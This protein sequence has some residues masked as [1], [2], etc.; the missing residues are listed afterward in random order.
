MWERLEWIV[1]VDRLIRAEESSLNWD[2]ILKLASAQQSKTS[3]LL[4][5]GL[6]SRLFNTPLPPSVQSQFNRT[7]IRDLVTFIFDTLNSDLISKDHTSHEKNLK[8]FQFHLAL[9]DSLATKAGFIFQTLFGYSDR[10]VMVNLPRS[11]FFLYYPLRIVRIIYKYT[12]E[13]LK[14][15]FTKS[16]R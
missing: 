2:E 8:V 12:L 5:L 13:P 1:D 16:S 11:L 9:Q 6:S 3:L 14:N 10:D 4:G 7:Q 15:L